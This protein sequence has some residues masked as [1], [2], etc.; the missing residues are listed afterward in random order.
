[1]VNWDLYQ[2]RLNVNGETQRER[3]I[4][5]AKRNISEGSI[6]S[7]ACK[8]VLVS[9]MPRKLMV[10]STNKDNEKRIQTLPNETISLGELVIWNEMHWM[11]NSIDF[12]DEIYRSGTIVQ[13]NRIICWQNPITLEI[14]ERWCF[15]SKPYTSNI[16]EGNVVSTLNGK[17]DIQIPYDSETIQV[18]VD[19]RLMLDVIGGKPMVYKLTFPDANTNKIQDI[20]GGFIEWTVAS[21]AY[22]QEKDNVELMIC[23]YIE[24]SAHPEPP[25]GDLLKCKIVGR[26]DLRIGGSPRNYSAKFYAADGVTEV[27]D[28]IS[29]IWELIAPAGH[30]A[31]YKI[32]LSNGNFVASVSAEAN[33]ALVEDILTFKLVDELGVYKSATMKIEVTEF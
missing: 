27:K 24:P 15:C 32:S 17:Y 19:K 28:G 26:S 31:Y 25:V 4:S 2:K 30:E 7:P 14:I 16:N 5:L 10:A 13:C 3:T 1:M 6:S 11:V 12:D 22:V 18:S 33:D 9:D 29:P 8:E 20:D 21:D 23:D